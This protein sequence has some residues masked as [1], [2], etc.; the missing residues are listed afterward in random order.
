MNNSNL[1]ELIAA[2]ENVRDAIVDSSTRSRYVSD[3]IFNMYVVLIPTPED[4]G[5]V[6]CFEIDEVG[7]YDTVTSYSHYEDYD[8]AVH[9]YERIDL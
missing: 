1:N 8:H 5:I 2:V 6:L 7:N 9:E 4:G 3:G